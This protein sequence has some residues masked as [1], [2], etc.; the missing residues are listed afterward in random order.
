MVRV[1][2]EGGCVGDV[3]AEMSRRVGAEYAGRPLRLLEVYQS[4]IY[5]VCGGGQGGV[6]GWGWGWCVCV[7]RGWGGGF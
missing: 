1:P 7:A 3:L 4:K 2:R 6:R 5:K